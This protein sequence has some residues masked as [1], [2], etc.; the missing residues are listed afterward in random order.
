MLPAGADSDGSPLGAAAQ[1]GLLA[2]TKSAS[3]NQTQTHTKASNAVMA[4]M[5]N[6]VANPSCVDTPPRGD[7]AWPIA[8]PLTIIITI[9]FFMITTSYEEISET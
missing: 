9:R 5:T 1:F 7:M 3:R 4:L 2:F 8:C 6:G